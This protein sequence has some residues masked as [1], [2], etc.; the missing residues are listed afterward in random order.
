MNEV[1]LRLENIMFRSVKSSNRCAGVGHHFTIL[2]RVIDVP[3]NPGSEILVMPER[4][5]STTDLDIVFFQRNIAGKLGEIS[6][7][8]KGDASW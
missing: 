2:R 7:P 3:S 4:N 5:E 1:D 8:G 6:F